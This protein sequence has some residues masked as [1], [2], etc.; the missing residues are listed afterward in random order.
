[1]TLVGNLQTNL[2][3]AAK[4]GAGGGVFKGLRQSDDLGNNLGGVAPSDPPCKTL[5]EHTPIRPPLNCLDKE[6]PQEIPN[7]QKIALWVLQ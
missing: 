1:M 2:E 3:I 5:V 7:F 4:G 6:P